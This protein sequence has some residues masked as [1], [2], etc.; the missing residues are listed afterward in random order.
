LR[1]GWRNRPVAPEHLYDLF[2]DPAELHNLIEDESCSSIVADLR[3]RLEQWMAETGDPLLD[4]PVPPPPGAEFN[5]PDQ[6]SPG[7]PTHM[8]APVRSATGA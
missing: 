2:F 7:E 6:V 8:S 4:G 5:D 3:D 1:N